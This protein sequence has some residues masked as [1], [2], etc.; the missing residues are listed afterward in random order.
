MNRILT[1]MI[2]SVAMLT[3][4][5]GPEKDAGPVIGKQTPD[6]SKGIMTPEILWSFGRIG[7]VQVSPDN[8]Q[9]VYT[10][11]YFSIPENKSNS[12]IFVINVDGSGKKQ[13]TSSAFRESAPKWMKDGKR[14]AYLSNESGSTQLWV[15]NADGSHQ[16]QITKREGGISDF[17][18]SPDED[19]LLFVAEVKV[20][21][22][23]ADIHP[24][25]PKATGLLIDDLMYKHWDEWVST[26][27]HPFIADFDGKKIS[28]EKD[29]LEGEPYE[30]PVKPMG[31]IEQLAWTPDGKKVAYCSRKKTGKAYSVSTNTDIY[32]YD[33]ATQQTGNLTEGM[34]GYDMN[35]VFSPDGKWMAWE[36]Q[37]RDGYEADKHR[38][39]V[40][41]METGEKKDLS[42][43]F[44]QNSESLI[45]S[46]DSKSLYFVSVWHALSQ[47]YRADIGAE[48]ITKITEGTH[49]YKS[50][51]PAGDKLIAVKCSMS[52]PHEIYAVNPSTGEETE[53]S[54]ENKDI[55][56]KVEMGKVEQRWVT[57][58]D[59]KQML[60]WV[61]Y[62]PKFD[63][64]KKYPT[65]LY[66]QG[67]PQSAVSQFWS[68]R[69][70][71]QTF[72]ANDYIIVAPNR[73]GLP[74]FGQEWLEQISGD[75]P[76][77]NMKDYLS[78]I[79][80]LAK[81]PFVDETRLGAVGASYGGYS[82]FWLAGNHNK[83]FKAFIAHAGIFN[84]EQQYLETEEM[85]FANWDMGGAYWD[86]ENAVAQNT[87]INSPHK[88]V[89]R[90]DTP[91]L[92]THGEKD[93]RILASQGMAAFNAAVLR[94][95]P[96]KLLVYPD[97][98][99]WIMKPQNGILWQRT[100]ASWLDQWLKP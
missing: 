30:S 82:V 93:Y 57:T 58:T 41:N 67:G 39:F 8:S 81:E 35:P 33:L 54:F 84:L 66:C 97:E 94:G 25:L 29:I 17:L 63:P 80:A 52:K 34:M 14:I 40:M 72:V 99:H 100:F 42:A 7:A 73:R 24:D 28:N 11:S 21:P 37:E 88:F 16:Q 60:V 56:E 87:Y 12:E 49:D 46:A 32:L 98:N 1:A 86:K 74:G 68:Y 45:W 43:N 6:T 79:D 78:A 69:W 61:I 48:I 9:I 55:L 65:I 31:G 47:I 64:A 15:M 95:V 38:L 96:A 26:V 85:W 18:F 90:W 3:T 23:T 10:V 53:L 36:S 92:V 5:C 75:Y 19:K 44:D 22:T 71:L 77:Q 20:K 59:N 51:Y 4:A 91:I 50:V 13:L 70:N 62:P 2:M 27:P 89:D 76:G 83:R